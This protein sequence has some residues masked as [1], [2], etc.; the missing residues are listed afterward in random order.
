VGT[1]TSSVIARA[2]SSGRLSST[3]QKAP[4]SVTARASSRMRSLANRLLPC[5]LKP[6]MACTD[7]GVSPTCPTTGMPAATTR[8]IVS[9]ISSPPSSFTDSARPS[10]TSRAADS[11]ACSGETL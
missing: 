4:A 9:A 11:R 2:S 8:A 1:G 5:I 7:W 3:R 6:P 10:C